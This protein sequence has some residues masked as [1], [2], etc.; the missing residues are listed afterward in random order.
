MALW[1]GGGFEVTAAVWILDVGYDLLRLRRCGRGMA[2][3]DYAMGCA[4]R[5]MLGG[6][7]VATSKQAPSAVLFGE[8]GI[9]LVGSGQKWAPWFAPSMPFLI[10]LSMHIPSCWWM[11]VEF[12]RRFFDERSS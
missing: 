1:G 12:Q 9:W 8:E 2:V 7:K 3:D 10:L 5:G 4:A 11:G 6:R